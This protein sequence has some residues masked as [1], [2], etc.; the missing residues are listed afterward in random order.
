MNIVNHTFLFIAIILGFIS[1]TKDSDLPLPS[2]NEPI[3][4]PTIDTFTFA[5]S[6][7]NE[8]KIY[9][10]ASYKTNKELPVIY[11][12]DFQEQHFNVAT[13]EFDKVVEASKSIVG[14]EAIVVGLADLHNISTH[15]GNTSDYFSLFKDLATYVDD[16][17]GLKGSKT[18]VGRGSEAGVIL[19]S[20][21]Q[22][23][24]ESHDFKNFVVTGPPTDFIMV[25]NTLITDETFPMDKENMRLHYS[26]S[27]NYE[28]SR[29][30]RMIKHIQE[31]A[32]PWL[33]FKSAEYP[34]LTFETAYPQAYAHGIQFVFGK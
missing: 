31:K 11:L 6:G 14:F 34:D 17:Y 18:L 26:F 23:S 24:G 3:N 27:D 32:Y 30:N 29:N 5:T 20:L 22:E 4:K 33:A 25:A 12:M 21:F 9:L 13:D 16:S 15:T 7:I 2:N 1:C 8:G 10:P 19:L 28:L